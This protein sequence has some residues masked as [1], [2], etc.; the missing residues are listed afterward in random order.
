MLQL[1]EW[2]SLVVAAS[3]VPRDTGAVVEALRQ[4]RDASPQI[5]DRLFEELGNL[6]TRGVELLA[7]RDYGQLG[8]LMNVAHG[9]LNALGVS[10][11]VIED[12]VSRAREAG[13]V[14]AKLTGAGGG[15][16]I[17]ALCPGRA[18]DV[19]TALAAAGYRVL[20]VSGQAE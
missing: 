11:P 10:M 13:A 14:G 18:D 20:R 1:D 6:S 9:T 12:M 7:D 16:S 15:G 2:P 4:R 8:V 19:Q 17:V 3:G 5:Y